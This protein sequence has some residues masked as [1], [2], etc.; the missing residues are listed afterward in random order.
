MRG[1][2]QHQNV[3]PTIFKSHQAKGKT[4]RFPARLNTI[5]DEMA[6]QQRREMKKPKTNISNGFRHLV[7]G[8][9]YITRGSQRWLIDMA[10]RTPVQQYYQE[11]Y[12]WSVKIFNLIAWDIQYK[13]M[14]TACSGSY[15]TTHSD[16]HCVATLSRMND[17]CYYAKS[18]ANGNST[19][20]KIQELPITNSIKNHI[21]AAIRDDQQSDYMTKETKNLNQAKIGWNQILSGRITSDVILKRNCKGANN[22]GK[23]NES[24]ARKLIKTIWDTI[25]VLWQQRNGF[26]YKVIMD[27]KIK[28]QKRALELR[29]ERCY[30]YKNWMSANN[31][32]RI[33]MQT[34]DT[35]M[36][37]KVKSIKAWVKLAER[38][39]RTNK[40][41]QKMEKGPRKM[42]ENYIN[43]HPPDHKDGRKRAKQAHHFKEDLKPD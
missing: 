18:N 7:I 39:I 42:M 35:L 32:A 38:I 1:I 36:Q 2:Q 24:L 10:S 15:A 37:Q 30:E 43:W 8:E 5:A 23:D 16:V 9:R 13:V 14:I 17:T 11:K 27:D 3:Q 31:Q 12:G 20:P 22:P 4:M 6:A 21:I 34:K 26:I 33:Y 25:L 40:K 29:V 41:E 28:Q 19:K